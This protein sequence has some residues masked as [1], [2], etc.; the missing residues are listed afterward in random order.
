MRYQRWPGRLAAQVDSDFAGCA[1]TRRS[2]TGLALF[3]GEHLIKAASTTQTVVALSSGEAEFNAIVR[4][5]AF[6]LGAKSLAKDYGVEV[7]ARVESDS[8]AGIGMSQRLGAGRVRHIG[9]HL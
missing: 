2:S 9:T 3:H 5:T 7:A 6:T 1:V 8:T 4:G